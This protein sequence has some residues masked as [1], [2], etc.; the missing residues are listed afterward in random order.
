MIEAVLTDNGLT[1]TGHA[2]TEA[3]PGQNIVCA[4]V[5]ALTHTLLLGLTDIAGMR[6]RARE[7]PGNVCVE[8]QE[9]NDTGKAIIDTWYLG[10]LAIQEAYGHIEFKRP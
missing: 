5:S 6:I 10:M 7:E 9:I 3:P 4:A 8:W 1:M 2:H